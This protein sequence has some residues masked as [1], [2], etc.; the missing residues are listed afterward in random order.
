MKKNNENILKYIFIIILLILG[1]IPITS[2]YLNDIKQEKIEKAR[3]EQILKQQQIEL[4]RIQDEK[5]KKKKEQENLQKILYL[6]GKFI[7]KNNSDFILIP[8]KYTFN[9]SSMYLRKETLEAFI[10]MSEAAKKEGVSLKIASATRNFEYQKNLWNNKWSGVTLV[11]GKKL[12]ISTPN[13]LDRFKK[14]LEY[15][16]VPTTSRHHW[17]TDIDINDANVE[18]FNTKQGILVYDWLAKNAPL[19]GFCQPYNEKNVA[20]ING[21]NEEKWHW[22][23]LPLAKN[24]TEEYKNLITDDYIRGFDGDEYVKDMDIINNYILSINPECL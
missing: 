5:E 12:P 1:S 11:D 3:L 15:S 8:K 21:Y 19:F 9:P 16:A 17:G 24:F 22:S 23:Y 4:K 13:G 10:K 18:Y 7:P 20:R 14:I 6:T 2:I